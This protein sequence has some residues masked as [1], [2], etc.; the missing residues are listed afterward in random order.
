MKNF[1][2]SYCLIGMLYF[3]F[4]VV[5]GADKKCALYT[6]SNPTGLAKKQKSYLQQW[7]PNTGNLNKIAI[8]DE[9]L[10]ALAVRDDGRFVAV[11]TMFSGSISIYIA[12]S[13]QVKFNCYL[14]QGYWL[15]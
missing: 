9:S 1:T 7:S 4:G 6:I 5:E 13:L 10:S 2:F 12:F 11:G 8:I 15:I 3:R 14:L